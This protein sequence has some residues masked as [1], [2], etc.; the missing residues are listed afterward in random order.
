MTD[1]NWTET[2]ER[3]IREG[4]TVSGGKGKDVAN[5][6][7]QQELDMQQK[8]NATQ[9]ALLAQMNKAY[10]PYLSG[11]IGFD[12]ALKASMTSQFLNNNSSTFNSAG[13]QVREA[14]GARGS[15]T[16]QNPVGGDYARGLSSL[17]GARAQ[18]QSQGL[19]GIN[20]Q[21]AQQA[22]QNQFNAG[23]LLSG[24]AAILTGTQGVAGSG[25]SSAL[26]DYIKAAN[27]GLA[28]SFV[29]AFGQGLGGG[30]GAG[31]TGGLG[32]AIGGFGMG[33]KPAGAGGNVPQYGS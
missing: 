27:S 17:L 30:L 24:N 31:L 19:L 33:S 15:G 21:N 9:S 16:G 22:L 25:A 12:P 20:T 10:S 3:Y 8:A 32:S 14:L 18:S 13:Q 2:I 5:D 4:R 28:Q 23:N 26:G 6:Q 1:M 29:G 7:R 11:K